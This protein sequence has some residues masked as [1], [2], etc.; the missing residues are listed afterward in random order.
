MA[1]QE[2]AGLKGLAGQIAQVGAVG[3]IMLMF[4]QD[5]HES[6]KTAAADR[7]MFRE[8][9]SAQRTTLDKLSVS[10]DHLARRLNLNT[11]AKEPQ[12]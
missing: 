5:R 12:P 11:R 4:Y 2:V 1:E 7:A 3:L 6:L 9:L 10:V 8:E